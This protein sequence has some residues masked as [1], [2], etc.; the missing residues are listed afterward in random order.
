MRAEEASQSATSWARSDNQ[1]IGFDDFH[2]I[3][4]GSDWHRRRL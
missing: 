3:F 4:A 1:E 2:F